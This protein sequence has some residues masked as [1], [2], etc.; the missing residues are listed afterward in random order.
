MRLGSR[1]ARACVSTAQRGSGTE[2]HHGKLR[3]VQGEDGRYAVD[4]ARV[5]GD[6]GGRDGGDVVSEEAVRVVRRAP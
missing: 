2:A 3:R 5:S 4:A 6:D 1:A